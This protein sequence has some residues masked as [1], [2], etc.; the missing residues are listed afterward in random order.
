MI[1][2][3]MALSLLHL[4]IPDPITSSP[5]FIFTLKNIIFMILLMWTKPVS[6]C[7]HFV[8]TISTSSIPSPAQWVKDLALLHLWHSLQ[9]QLRFDPWSG[10]F[11]MLWI[12]LKKKKKFH[13]YN[14]YWA[15]F[16]IFPL[17]GNIYPCSNT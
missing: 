13:I 1:L 12:W 15:L 6:F 3:P 16:N 4:E 7:E 14:I 11:H 2:S 8:L 17:V 9:L 10:N 5:N